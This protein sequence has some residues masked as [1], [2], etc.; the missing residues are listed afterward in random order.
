MRLLN[1]MLTRVED[2]YLA[3]R[4]LL[5]G[6]L[7]SAGNAEGVHREVVGAMRA[8]REKLLANQLVAITVGSQG[9]DVANLPVRRGEAR[10]ATGPIHLA[11]ST[12]AALLPVFVNARPGGGY[13]VWVE[14]PLAV[15][16]G[17]RADLAPVLSEY[18][19]GMRRH[20]RRFGREAGYWGHGKQRRRNR[21]G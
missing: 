8:V 18:L 11:A 20:L 10:I 21:E 7:E 12:G 3:G 16:A 6:H 2:R 15:P 19:A 17:R 4:I 1:P 5:G 13:R 14:G 9:R